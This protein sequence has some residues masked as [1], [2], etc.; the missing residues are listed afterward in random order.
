MCHVFI[1]TTKRNIW[2]QFPLFLFWRTILPK[3]WK[4]SDL[5]MGVLPFL[6]RHCSFRI[7]PSVGLNLNSQSERKGE[8]QQPRLFFRR[9]KEMKP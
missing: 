3:A 7:Y 5:G 4:T 1:Y 2:L 6:C 9:A 8:E